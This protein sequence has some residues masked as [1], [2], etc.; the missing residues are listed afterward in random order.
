[1]CVCARARVCVCPHIKHSLGDYMTHNGTVNLDLCDRFITNLS[2]E[3]V[4]YACALCP[5]Y[6]TQAMEN[7]I[8][9][10]RVQ[11]ERQIRE[12][13]RGKQAALGSRAVALGC[14]A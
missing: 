4:V 1:V 8:L 10:Q 12:R 9:Q 14:S 13:Q 2:V 11:R 7:S 6:C 5:L 3:C